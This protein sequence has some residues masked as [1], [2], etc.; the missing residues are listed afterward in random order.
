VIGNRV[1][2]LG[3]RVLLGE[4]FTNP[5]PLAILLVALAPATW[6]LFGL[7]LIFRFWAAYA[8]SQN[9][10]SDP[11]ARGLWYLIPVQDVLSFMVW[12]GGSGVRVSGGAGNG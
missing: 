10:L 11:L 12:T 2:K 6:P 8:T 4:I 1:G 9:V 5:I 7:S 3:G